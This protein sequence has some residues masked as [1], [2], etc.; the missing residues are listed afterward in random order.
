MKVGIF[1]RAVIRPTLEEALDAIRGYGM[2]SVQFSL[3]SAGLPDMPDVLEERD[4]HR[5]R[6]AFDQQG[7]EMAALSGTFNMIHPDARERE[8]G[9]RRLG[10]LLENCSRL[11]ASIVTLCTGTRNPDSMWR[12]HPENHTS[13]AWADLLASM[14]RA[15]RMAE[16]H[17][18]TL[19][20]ESEVNNVV[21]SADKARRLIDEIRSPCLKV[22]IDGA[23]LFHAGE[24]PRMS[25]ILDHAFDVLG[26]HI[27]L[28]H[29][30]DLNRD[31]DAGHDAAGTGLLDY[32][33]YIQRL[34]DIGFTGSIVLHS[35]QESQISG[36]LAFVRGSMNRGQQAR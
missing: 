13:E 34:L 9:L 25:E 16:D 33:R 22:V 27:V 11:D 5:I 30:K 36:C 21:D 23:N 17:G 4:C 3:D 26:D 1:T 7:M 14:E 31:G 15:A 18:V 19:A 8:A 32:D 20:L 24:L 2:I 6:E 12:H 28:A 29:A 10:V 35:L